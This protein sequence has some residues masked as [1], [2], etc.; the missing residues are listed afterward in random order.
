MAL[1]LYYTFNN[2]DSKDYSEKGLNGT[3]TS[4]TYTAGDVGY[5][6]TFNA[7][8]DAI[9]H[10]TFNVLGGLTEIGFYFRIKLATTT[11]TKYICFKQGQYYCTYNGTTLSFSIIGATGTAT[12]STTVSRGI[13]YQFHV[14]YLHNGIA[15]D[16]S[17]Y[18]DGVL[19]NSTST[20]GAVVSNTNIAYI[21]G[22]AGLGLSD[23]A[24]FEMSEYK[25]FSNI[26]SSYNIATHL[27]NV[28][29]LKLSV[30]RDVYELGDIIASKVNETNK[31]YAIVTFVNGNDVRIQPLN[32]Y[33]SSNDS[34]VRI[35]HLWDTTR[36][37]SVQITSTGINFYNGVALSSQAFT[38]AKLVKTD[39]ITSNSVY[40][41]GSLTTGLNNYDVPVNSFISINAGASASITG[42]VAASYPRRIVII[43]RSSTN[44][45]RL[46]NNSGSSTAANRF[47][48]AA[49]YDIPINKSVEIFY[50]TN[51]SRWRLIKE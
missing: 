44:A 51:V 13:Y 25:I 8:G 23:T 48:L 17:I 30:S 36:Q 40:D 33:I 4:I 39:T 6:A 2:Q 12:V 22:D 29:G 15:N 19:A 27:L 32:A 34:F 24:N 26:L 28:N 45:I 16:M 31:G 43:N 46:Y 35:G 11:G 49:D 9:S 3:D 20:Q 42:I 5:N 7:V 10:G 47:D 38:T 1:E 41:Y 37:Y 21:G 18:K 50:D 14:N